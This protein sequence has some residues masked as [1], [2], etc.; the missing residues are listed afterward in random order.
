MTN[1][2]STHGS[3]GQLVTLSADLNRADTVETAITRVVELAETVFDQPTASIYEYDSHTGTTTCLA[4]STSDATRTDGAPGRIPAS[5]IE[6]FGE[7]EAEQPSDGTPEAVVEA[8]SEG[9]SQSEMFALVGHDRLLRLRVG[10]AGEVEDDAVAAVEGIAASLETALGRIDQQQ[11]AA[12]DCNAL[13]AVFDH[14][15]DATF[16]SDTNGTLVAVN[17]AAVELTGHSR[18]TLLTNG[19]AEVCGEAVGEHLKYAVDG[20]SEPR[21]TTLRCA[22]ETDLP[23]ELTSERI[24]GDGATYIRTTANAR[25]TSPDD[26]PERDETVDRTADAVTALRRLNELTVNSEE[27]DGTIEKLLALGCD[28][29]SLDTGILSSIDGDDYEVEAVV[30]ATGMHEPGAVYDLG[31]TMCQATLANDGAEPLAFADVADT[32]HES[33]PASDSVSAYIAAPV[34]VDEE[35]YG[36][37]NFSMGRPRSTAFN[38][39]EKEF[40]KLVAQWVGSEIERRRRFQELERYETILEAVGDPVYAL[41]PE[42]RF[43]YVNEAARREFGYGTEIIGKRP[44][45]GMSEADIERI[46]EQIEDLLGTDEQS[47]TAE[48]ELETAGESRTIV[49]NRLALIGDDAFRGTAGVLRDITDREERQR[50]LESFQRAIEEA[51]DGIAILDGDEYTYVDQSHVDMYGFDDRAQLLGSSW[52]E[53]YDDAEVERLEA[54][55]FPAL[56]SEGH[57]RGMVTGSRPDGST[58]PAEL[59]LTIVGDGRL[60]CTVRDE[61][62]RQ[63]RERELELKERAMNEATVGIQITDPNQQGNPL[64]YVNNGF[65]RLTGYASEEAI[66]RNPRFLQ[67]EDTDPEKV[68]ELR[69]AIRNEEPV[70]LELRNY[71]KDGTPYWTRL[72]ITPVT[73]ENGVVQNFI[74]IQQDVTERWERERELAVKE[75]AMN[76]A[77]VGITIS[78]PNR[79][80]NP[81]V[82]VNDGF[83]K[84]TGYTREEAVGQNCRFLQADDRDQSALDDLREAIAA[85]ETTTV[86][87]RNYRKDGEQFWNRLS[88]TPVYD[89]SGTLTNYVGIQQDVTEEKRREER[90]RALLGTTRELLQTDD[91]QD[92]T[93]KV[94]ETI[95]TEF[96]FDQSAVYLRA[97]DELVR[98]DAHG[99]STARP[100]ARIKRG[101]S[102]LW[103]AVEAGEVIHYDD[104]TEIDDGIDR[105]NITASG[106]FPVGDHGAVVV[107]VTDPSRLGDIE[108]QLV[109]VVTKNLAAVLDSLDR[110]DS[111]RASERRYRSLAENIPNGAVGIFNTDL[112]YTLA[113]GELL[114]DLGIDPA[115]AIGTRIDEV[116][117]GVDN[118]DELRSQFRAALDGERTDRRIELGGMT[119]RMHVV[120]V[121][122]EDGESD[123]T[124]GLVL[125]QDVTDEARRERELFEERERFRLLTESVDEY[126]FLIVDEDGTVQ[127]WNESAENLFGYDADTAIGMPMSTFH[128]EADRE[129]GVPE[130]VL[131]QARLA[132]ESAN[133]GWRIRADGS[134]FYADVRYAPLEGDNGEFRGYAKIV[135]DMTERRRQRRR[136]E[137]FVE[138]SNDV[139]TV[140]DDD[141]TITY[142]SGSASRVLGYEPDDL[143]GE[144]LF[145]YIHPDS[146]EKAMETFFTGMED[147]DADLQAEC[148]LKSG[149]GEWRNVRGQCRNMLGDDAIDGML[150]YLRDVTEHKERARRFE[151]IF[152]Q[153]FQFTGLLESDGTV[154]EVNRA[155]VDFTGVE[156]DAVVGEPL[157]EAPW[158][159]VSE[160][161]E[162]DLRNAMDR[163]ANGEFVRYETEVRGAEGLATIDFSLKP[164]TDEDGDISLIVAEGRDITTQQQHRR[165]LE[166]MQRVMRHNMRNDLTKVRGWTE[167]M[168]DEPDPDKRTEHL[169]T[170]IG[171]IEKWESMIEKMQ[172]IRQVLQSQSETLDRAESE[173]LIHNA[174]AAVREQSAE[175]TV[176]TDVSDGG[177]TQLPA[178][179]AIAIRELIKNS[180]EARADATVGVTLSHLDEGWVE[181]SVRDDGPGLPDMEADVLETGEESPLNH[182]QGLGLWMVRMIVI[183]S[184]GDVSVD[185][186]P[187]GTEVRLRL[188]ATDDRGTLVRAGKAD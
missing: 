69:S 63:A 157:S 56:E 21:T 48:F 131:Q 10:D 118:A 31:E 107:G 66:G 115:E 172:E 73:D 126:A 145:D 49:E 173:E 26:R 103:D 74:G 147:P 110:E 89:E 113:A 77:D 86:E 151:S 179:I 129:S 29:F 160:E 136:T 34:I 6:R 119:I 28:H 57:W 184:G 4:A 183:R 82:Y 75:R 50:Q 11:S 185:S 38:A 122:P 35:T 3:T 62:E 94:A 87:L 153:T 112:E 175:A 150:L 170:V 167:V 114:S 41:D 20:A 109:E 128:T 7:R 139:I 9:S 71:R 161:V 171:I 32:E 100:P 67:G 141:G 176:V 59:S 72:S 138:E 180:I 104:C 44:S 39:E 78:D 33:H 13:D 123:D 1:A 60:V 55:A 14:S 15:D 5:V 81:L 166:V 99:A 125:A 168:C 124:Q 117:V 95:A 8:D 178:T 58:F 156:R 149:D 22:D 142:A 106:Y 65:E 88:V 53:L 25:P 159:A 121:D 45:V 19:F 83:V 68:E 154:L 23:V 120:P 12:I 135:R 102:P 85:E 37:V 51:A 163:A 165:H 46:R 116:L 97:E 134:T 140:V 52:R 152:N 96:G 133:E 61:T 186:T 181:I 182:G 132:G 188:P 47:I 148:R 30:D 174:V 155:T 27:F 43:T 162:D 111:L 127:T 164:V 101:L 79:A 169:E 92:A 36:T 177:E 144:N 16:V 18:E 137:R 80:D 130:R 42:G 24:D 17:R 76:E 90:L 54:E 105:G 2:D 108:R 146:R 91:A 187:D 84:Q 93:A 40:V 158:W 143:V 70:A 64:V 98:T